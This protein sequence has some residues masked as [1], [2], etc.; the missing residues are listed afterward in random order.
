LFLTRIVNC[1]DGMQNFR[2]NEKYP[3]KK[4]YSNHLLLW[5]FIGCT[6]DGI[7]SAYNISN[8]IDFLIYDSTTGKGET[9]VTKTKM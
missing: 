8:K 2:L 4:P 7:G 3:P 5:L 6:G 9:H 1:G